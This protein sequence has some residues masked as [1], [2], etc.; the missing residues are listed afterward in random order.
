MEISTVK[1]L[2]R[3]MVFCAGAALAAA[4]WAVPTG[5]QFNHPRPMQRAQDEY[6]ALLL[7][8]DFAGLE[9]IADE[10]RRKD[11]RIAD[12]QPVLAALYEATAGCAC[13]NRLTDELWQLR[14]SRLDEWR[15]QIPESQTARV[16]SAAFPVYYAWLA[17]GNNYGSSVSADAWQ[18]F[19]GRM[20]TGRI[21]LEEL[22]PAA[23]DDQG[24]YAAMM[25][26]ALAQHWPA[27]R[28]DAL[29]EKAAR[30]HPGYLPIHFAAGNYYAP[31]WY[32]SQKSYSNFIER[33]AKLAG[34]QLGAELYTR[35]NWSQASDGMFQDGSV[36][37]NRMKSGFQQLIRDYADPWNL[38]NYA[39][40]ACMARDW[41]T[42]KALA[43]KIGDAPVTL[44]WYNDNRMYFQCRNFAQSAPN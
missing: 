9:R 39:R 33:A 35:M 11:S 31:Q 28:F 30:R 26:V 25:S 2:L 41:A 7:K 38:N 6:F 18:L 14:R 21:A 20:Q 17:R 13:N 4:L 32:G 44:A 10:A 22:D 12:G 3:R 23:K 5:A 8:R 42:M 19:N 34:P 24:W 36:D 29:Y 43:T 1:L 40:F 37:W 27:E 16:A 15:R